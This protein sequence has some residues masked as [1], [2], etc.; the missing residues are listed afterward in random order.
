M[1]Y[2]D[3]ATPTGTHAGS[4]DTLAA[5]PA[6]EPAL[7]NPDP[8]AG[9]LRD[10]T[11]LADTTVRPLSQHLN[12]PYRGPSPEPVP[13][14]DPV[15]RFDAG[16]LTG[17]QTGLGAVPMETYFAPQA[18]GADAASR[19]ALKERRR[20]EPRYCLPRAIHFSGSASGAKPT[21]A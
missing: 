6:G 14:L 2:T 17:R 13:V 18:A 12:L 7:L 4:G 1:R 21:C 11:D 3:T 15:G 5:R 16:K 10:G 19:A 20:P 9:E 8:G